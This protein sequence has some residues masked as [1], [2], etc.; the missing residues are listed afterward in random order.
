[1]PRTEP[2]AI[3]IDA[4][5]CDGLIPGRGCQS[6]Y[7]DQLRGT[8]EEAVPAGAETPAEPAG[9][10][11]HRNEAG[12]AQVAGSTGSTSDAGGPSTRSASTGPREDA[13]LSIRGLDAV[14]HRPGMGHFVPLK[15]SLGPVPS[16]ARRSATPACPGRSRA[17]TGR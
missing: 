17:P 11:V 4:H 5:I 3:G 1:V 7:G 9:N 15:E 10:V 2:G 12:A 13:N 6:Q 14:P 16:R 8:V